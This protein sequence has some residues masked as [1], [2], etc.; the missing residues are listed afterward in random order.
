M[1]EKGRQLPRREARCWVRENRGRAIGRGWSRFGGV[2]SAVC[3]CRDQQAC[4]LL[5]GHA[6]TSGG[7]EGLFGAVTGMQG[8]DLF[9]EA[10]AGNRGVDR[11]GER[12]FGPVTVAVGGLLPISASD[13]ES[14]GNNSAMR[15]LNNWD[16]LSTTGSLETYAARPEVVVGRG[17]V[18]SKLGWCRVVRNTGGCQSSD[19][20]VEFS[21]SG[22]AQRT[23]GSVR[24]SPRLQAGKAHLCLRR[25]H[26]AN[27]P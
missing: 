21:S 8:R 1:K 25:Q 7:C 2:Q 9:W 11:G 22:A 23:D 27:L 5:A 12:A 13:R 10:L 17:G 20:R 16:L 24:V 15:N 14:D 18:E 26:S 6:G 3:L 19:L 4:A